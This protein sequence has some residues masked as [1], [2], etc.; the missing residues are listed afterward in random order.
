MSTLTIKGLI[1]KGFGFC[2]GDKL[3]KLLT[4]HHIALKIVITLRK[5]QVDQLAA[6]A[7]RVLYNLY[8]SSHCIKDNYA[9][10]LLATSHHIHT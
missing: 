2:S 9:L 4:S 10:T 3:A 5:S 8:K 1:K 7:A 6:S